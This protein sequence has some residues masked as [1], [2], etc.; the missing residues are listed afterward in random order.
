MKRNDFLKRLSLLG[1]GTFLIPAGLLHSCTYA[2]KIRTGLTT[3]DI[4]LLDEIGEAIIPST[5]GTP[6]AK[7]TKIG[8]YMMLMVTDCFKPEDQQIFVDG[9]NDLDERCAAMYNHSFLDLKATQKLELL[10]QVQLEAI[11]FSTEQKGIE[12]P[13][14]HYFDLF[15]SLTISGYF[16][17]EIGATQARNYL[18][19]PGRFEACI[20]HQEG[21]R[22]WAT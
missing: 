12:K 17:S 18:P 14:P 15:K 19:V 21:D 6:G 13:K 5:G 4:P 20:P 2:A 16:T 7:A 8:T 9:L 11:T 3:N 1:S 10:E 22:P